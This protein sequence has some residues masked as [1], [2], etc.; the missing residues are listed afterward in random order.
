MRLG[1]VWL[2]RL[3][4]FG[5]G[6][7]E[8]DYSRRWCSGWWTGLRGKGS[9]ESRLRPLGVSVSELAPRSFFLCRCLTTRDGI[10]NAIVATDDKR[11][12]GEVHCYPTDND[13]ARIYKGILAAF[14]QIPAEDGSNVTFVAVVNVADN[15]VSRASKSKRL[16][17]FLRLRRRC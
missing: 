11:T 17:T 13:E 10:W 15:E 4:S 16:G 8:M 12:R 1:F 2:M 3:G 5:D 9:G 6:A 14:T 7:L